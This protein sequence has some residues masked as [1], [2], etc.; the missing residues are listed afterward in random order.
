MTRSPSG[1]VTFVFTDLEA[2]TRLWDEHPDA[3]REALARHDAILRNGIESNS[4]AVVK[5]TGA[6]MYAAFTAAPDAAAAAVEAMRALA[7]ETYDRRDAVGLALLLG[8]RGV[9]QVPLTLVE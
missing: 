2:S 7:S 3:M 9:A 6:G 5:T 4:G 8:R 1:A